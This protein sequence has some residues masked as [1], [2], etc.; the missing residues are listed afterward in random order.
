MVILKHQQS[1]NIILLHDDMTPIISIPK[2]LYVKINN[3]YD[4]ELIIDDSPSLSNKSDNKDALVIKTSEI[5][6]ISLNGE[7]SI[8]EG[9]RNDLF[10]ILTTNFFY[11]NSSTE[12]TVD[13]SEK[14]TIMIE[15]IIGQFKTGGIPISNSTFETG[16]DCT[17]A[18]KV[19]FCY[20]IDETLKRSNE[21]VLHLQDGRVNS[22]SSPYS[23]WHVNA[24]I[25]DKK[26]GVF[27]VVDVKKGQRIDRIIVF[28]QKEIT[29]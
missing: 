9:N 8:F 2:G 7:E 1:K 24:K 13:E 18:T 4:D 14:E 5:S 11:K 15:Y 27:N 20:A 3:F 17:E 23:T 19:V 26:N 21:S 25:I 12:D 22:L 16:I 6:K 10:N 28:G 29:I